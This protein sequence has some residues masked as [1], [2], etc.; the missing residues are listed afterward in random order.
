MGIR[1]L[2]RFLKQ[3]APAAYTTVTPLSKAERW[4]LDCSCIMY[5]ARAAGLQPVTVLA[6]LICKLR[7]IGVELIVIFDGKP[8]AVKAT[9]LEE[10]R[11]HRT[12]I[13]KEIDS[14]DPSA[15]EIQITALQRQIPTLSASDK[16][17]VKQLLYA[18]GVLFLNASGEADD[19]LAA[20][21]KKG[22]ITAVI[23]S[24]MDMLPRGI[25][26]VILPETAD[27]A[28]LTSVSLDRVLTALSLTYDQFV[29]ACVLMGSDYSER[30]MNPYQAVTAIQA[31]RSPLIET[32]SGRQL[33]GD[34]VVL[35]NLLTEA[36]EEKWAAGAP[37]VEP[38]ALAALA[39]THGWPP[40]W[41][42]ILQ[43]K[44]TAP[45]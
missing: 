25:G 35:S 32:E 41:V 4:A 44:L 43:T 14:L 6:G 23:S 30:S 20:L 38:E 10:R 28:T 1:G 27:A 29:A 13:Q 45:A 3:R 26:R 22:D 24:D 12:A 18:A 11:A 42:I 40:G 15:N 2:A 21:Y 34:G 33:K 39:A 16:D 5:R 36:Q 7:N 31:A 9:T 17:T 37:P 19:L 8:P